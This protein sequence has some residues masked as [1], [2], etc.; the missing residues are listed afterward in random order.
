MSVTN[1]E[2]A[3]VIELFEGL[4]DITHRKM[5][6]GASFYLDGQIFAILSPWSGIY[7]KA[8]GAFAETLAAEG[9]IKFE[10]EDGRTMGYWSLPDA[11]QDDPDVA[12][13]WGRRALAAL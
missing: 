2:I 9:S 11:A 12:C 1:D 13:D 7:L 10:T 8:K 5:M 3:H 6:G 4:G